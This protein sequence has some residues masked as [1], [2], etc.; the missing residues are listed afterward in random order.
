MRS[1][2][3]A[4]Y[5][6]RRLKDGVLAALVPVAACS[7]ALAGLTAWIG[8]GE[9]GSPARMNVTEGRVLLPSAGV[10]ETAAFFRMENKGGSADTLIRVTS[11]DVPG[12]I[13]LAR[14]RMNEGN[15][16]YRAGVESVGIPAGGS[17]V[18]SPQGVDLTVS[19]PA[20]KWRSGDLVPFTL[21]F[22]RSGRVKVLAVVVRP[23]SASFQ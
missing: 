23:G 17:V 6:R 15:G 20:S 13:T 19:A 22:R 5:D 1:T 14:H 12:G 18:M 21:E 10:T 11:R 3:T 16:A 8:T 2:T 9:A 7:V 4:L